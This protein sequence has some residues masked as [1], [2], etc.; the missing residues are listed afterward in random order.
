MFHRAFGC[1]LLVLA[2]GCAAGSDASTWSTGDAGGDASPPPGRDGASAGSDSSAGRDAGGGSDGSSVDDGPTQVG[3]LDGDVESG[4]PVL[5]PLTNVVA[6]E[7][8]DSVGIDFDPVEGA[9]DYRVYPLPNASDVTIN[10]DGSIQVKN[11]VYRCA[12]M[13]QTFDLENGSNASDPGL[14]AFNAPYNTKAQGAANPTLGYV[15]VTPGAGRV[16][17]H[18]I[19]GPAMQ[20][21]LGWRESRSKT[22]TTDPAQASMLLAQNGRDDGIVFYVPS[23]PS[24]GTQTVYSSQAMSTQYYFAAADMAQH[25]NDTVKPAPAFEVLTAATPDTQPL[26][27]V[28]YS[29]LTDPA[30]VELAVG[31]ERYK[32]ALNQGGGPLWHLEWAGLTQPTVLVV[33]ALASGCP[34]QGFLSATHLDAPPHQTFDTLG[35]LRASS[36]TGEVF[37]NGEYDNA[38]A[39][40]IPIARSFVQ[41]S[42][43]PHNP[44]DWDFYQGFGVGTDLGTMT[45]I[46]P[47]GWQGGRVQTN[48]LDVSAFSLDAPNNVPVFTFGSFQGQLWEAFDDTGQGVTGRVRITAKPMASVASGSFLHVT[49]S[50]N[51]VSTDRRYPQIIVSDQPAPVDCFSQ[52]CP[53]FGSSGGFAN[54]LGNP[55]SNTLLVQVIQGPSM[56]LETQAIHGLVKNEAWNVNNQAPE[57]RFLDNNANGSLS[58]AAFAALNAAA[59][60]VFEHAGM[61]R[62]TKFDAYI[63]SDRLYVLLDD[64][65]AGCTQ[66]P[67]GFTLAGPVSVTFGDVLYHEEV[68]DEMVC[69]QARPYDFM[70]VHQCTETSRHY[71]D[72]AFK[73]GVPAPKWDESRLPCV[74]Y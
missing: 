72:L 40:P 9:V 18:A 6:S 48:D 52:N 27:A 42:P 15:Y 37:V 12:G 64:A 45:T 29:P 13:R 74:A 54:G 53:G 43:Q 35:D 21:E 47:F 50:V 60:P 28:L 33:E 58:A 2:T 55:N 5:P 10:S 44:S 57:H 32:R 23:A 66:Y 26:M 70:H 3:Q 49:M 69:K 16:P 24:S 19:A 56:R 68:T 22:Y 31:K 39:S 71:D 41:V 51:I 7:R 8:D 67:S 61:D 17:V 11:A 63:S 20:V 62:M 59:D 34:Y 1:V 38:T 4:L 73:S 36:P 65:P 14:T 25:A 46:S 30:H